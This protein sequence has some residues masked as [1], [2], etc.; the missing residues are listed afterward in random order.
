MPKYRVH[1]DWIMSGSI[2]VE[3][4]SEEDAQEYVL[5]YSDKLD[6]SPLKKSLEVWEVEEMKV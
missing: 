1:Y 6:A 3:A 5:T 4:P 2:E